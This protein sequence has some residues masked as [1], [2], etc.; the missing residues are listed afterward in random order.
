MDVLGIVVIVVVMIGI[1]KGV[2]IGGLV[3]IIDI[4]RC[5]WNIFFV[6]FMGV[7]FFVFDVLF[8]FV[9]VGLW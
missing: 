5:G 9:V 6:F 8:L 2:G 3:I 4:R 7:L 1:G